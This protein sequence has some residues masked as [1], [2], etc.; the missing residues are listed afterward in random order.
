LGDEAAE[1]T[2]LLKAVQKLDYELYLDIWRQHVSSRDP[3]SAEILCASI[4][5]YHP[6]IEEIVENWTKSGNARLKKAAMSA[7][8]I[9]NKKKP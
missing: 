2:T 4:M 9:L 1:H 6:E 3:Q 5:S 7:Q 8:R